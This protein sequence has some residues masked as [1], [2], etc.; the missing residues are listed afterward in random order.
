VTGPSTPNL[1]VPA[2]NTVLIE[3]TVLVENTVL[4]GC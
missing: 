4:T 1:M 2:G 3:N